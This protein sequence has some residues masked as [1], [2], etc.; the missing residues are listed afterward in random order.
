MT[1]SISFLF[2]R[3][4]KC[5]LSDAVRAIMCGR[6]LEVMAEEPTVGGKSSPSGVLG[7]ASDS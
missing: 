6:R 3:N 4:L 5:K 7:S 2:T 1:G